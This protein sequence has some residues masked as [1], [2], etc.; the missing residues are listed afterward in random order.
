MSN[1]MIVETYN[2]IITIISNLNFNKHTD[3]YENQ[4]LDEKMF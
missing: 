2:I 1:F 4:V 3:I